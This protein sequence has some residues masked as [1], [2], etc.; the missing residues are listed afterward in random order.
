M[1]FGCYTRVAPN[2]ENKLKLKLYRCRVFQSIM[3]SEA[4]M[5]RKELL[6]V[7]VGSYKVYDLS[8]CNVIRYPISVPAKL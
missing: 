2:N 3:L 5:K 4:S 6:Y 7:H 8:K 1:P